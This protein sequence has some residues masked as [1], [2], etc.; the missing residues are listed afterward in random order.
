MNKATIIFTDNNDGGLEMQILQRKLTRL[1]K[2]N[3]PEQPIK[4]TAV[5]TTDMQQKTKKV[6]YFVV[7]ETT[8]TLCFMHL[9]CGFL[10]IGKSACVDPAKFNQALG[11]KYAYEDA[12]NK[13]WEL[14]GYLLANELYGDT[15]AS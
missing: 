1:L 8:T 4:R 7:P 3:Q 9:H 2:M 6:E 13:M 12:I 10:I 15:H 5:T 11:E 14:E